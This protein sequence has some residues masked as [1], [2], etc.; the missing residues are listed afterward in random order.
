MT[1][2]VSFV[3]DEN[4]KNKALEKAKQEG[5]TLKAV[6]TYAMKN[7]VEGKFTFDLVQTNANPE[8]EELT[9]DD[10]ALN[11]KTRKL[12]KLLK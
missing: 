1:T 10:K 11:K 8:V 9:F 12:A 2:Q 5:V 7:F 4:L 3:T 6:L